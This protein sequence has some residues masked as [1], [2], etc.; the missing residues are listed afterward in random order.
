MKEHIKH[1]GKKSNLP[2]YL[3]DSGVSTLLVFLALIITPYLFSGSIFK[4]Y[5]ESID[6]FSLTDIGFSAIVDPQYMIGDTNILIINISELNN[7]KLT[8]LLNKLI[9]N[10]PKTIGIN[11]ILKSE[12]SESDSILAKILAESKNIVVANRLI[13]NSNKYQK[14][15]IEYPDRIFSV[16]EKSCFNNLCLYKDPRVSTVREF[17]SYYKFGDSVLYS[18]P[19]QLI[20]DAYPLIATKFLDRKKEV[21]TINWGHY[22]KFHSITDFKDIVEEPTI[23]NLAH[24]KIVLLGAYDPEDDPNRNPYKLSDKYFTP[25]N[26]NYA[27]KAYPD[28]YETDIYANIISMILHENYLVSLPSWI[29]HLLSVIICFLTIFLYVFIKKKI[30]A[31]YELLSVFIFVIVSIIILQVTIYSFHLYNVDLQLNAGLIALAISSPVFEAYY[32]SVKPLFD[33]LSKLKHKK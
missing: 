7:F 15:K 14:P 33:K 25:L 20:M 27:G 2:E 12:N 22:K 11:R 5:R 17:H 16:N 1:K 21:E 28:M 18:F 29:N 13:L 3:V 19:M 32:R 6:D 10:E 30:D 26:P 8:W 9:E 24:G 31:W 4:P 23:L